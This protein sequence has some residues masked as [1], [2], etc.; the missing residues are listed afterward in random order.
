MKLNADTVQTK[1][2]IEKG[3]IMLAALSGNNSFIGSYLVKALSDKGFQT[4]Q[5]T[6]ELLYSP[7]DL[8]LFFEEREP[9]YIFHLAAYGNHSTQTDEAMTVLSNI[10]GT[11]NMLHASRDIN[12]KKFVN[13]STSSVKLPVET[14][15]SASKA[16]A[17]R[18]ANAFKQQGKP[19]LTIRPY[20]VYGGGEA[21]F[22]FIPTICNKLLADEEILLD[23]NPVHDWIYVENF[24]D[25]VMD[26]LDQDGI[27]EIG[28]GVQTTNKQIVEM[29]EKISGIT[30]KIK[31][32]ENQRDYD[33]SEWKA[34]NKTNSNLEKGL[35]KTWEYYKK[36]Y[37]K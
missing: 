5:V 13:F 29:L 21:L 19:I 25:R 6:R 20:S 2:F 22:R 8:R 26:Y 31:I 1:S 16:G 10:I 33:T 24:V 18:I 4:A 12:Y 14:F 3:G 11:F 34:D 17:E 32:V 23:P 30:A 37:D 7:D 28:T 9:D 15:Y 27:V 35:K 36:L